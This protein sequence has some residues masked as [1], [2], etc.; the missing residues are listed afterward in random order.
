MELI[1]PDNVIMRAVY[2]GFM[3]YTVGM[4]VNEASWIAEKAFHSLDE[5]SNVIYAKNDETNDRP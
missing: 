2:F 4:L 1:F 3:A 5:I